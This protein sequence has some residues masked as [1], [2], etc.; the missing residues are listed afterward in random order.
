MEV[1]SLIINQTSTVGNEALFLLDGYRTGYYPPGL[2]SLNYPRSNR[3]EMRT[4]WNTYGKWDLPD[5]QD[6]IR[7]IQNTNP[8][9]MAYPSDE[10]PQKFIRT[11]KSADGWNVAFI[12]E[13]SGVPIVSAQCYHLGNDRNV[14]LTGY[15]NHSKIVRIQDF[16]TENCGY[17]S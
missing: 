8:E 12:T 14:S 7:I 11:E 17:K 4:W 13:G 15:F 1:R 5:E 6:A 9:L 3:T 10:F 16:S 2:C